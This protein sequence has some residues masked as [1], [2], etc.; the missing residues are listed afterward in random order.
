MGNDSDKSVAI[1][2]LDTA[3]QRYIGFLRGWNKAR[4]EIADISD[5][6]EKNYRARIEKIIAQEELLKERILWAANQAEFS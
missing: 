3:V 4:A 2:R 5:L 1:S 6:P